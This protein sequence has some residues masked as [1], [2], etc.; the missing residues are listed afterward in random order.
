MTEIFSPGWACCLDESMSIWFNRYTCP[1]WVFC[2]RKPHPWG[3]EYHSISCGTSGIMFGI[4]MVEG[5]HRPKEIPT[6][7]TNAKG[8]TV[9]LLLRLCRSIYNSGR[10][11]ILDSGFCVLQGLI[12]LRKLGVYA[13][14]I[15][16]KRRYWPKHVPGKAMDKRM[17]SKNIGEVDCI[18]G[19]LDNTDYNLFMMKEPDFTMKMMAT[20]GALNPYSDERDSKRY[21]KDS[22]GNSTITTFKYTEPYSNHYRFRHC[23]NNHNNLRHHLSSIEGTWVTQRWPIRVLG[24]LLAISEVNTFLAFRHFVWHTEEESV[25]LRTF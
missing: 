10:V 19:K 5:D 15:I 23:V 1:G 18:Q 11:V 14:A 8:N 13:S 22:D 24:F 21:T 4:E 3:N 9:G 20:Y 6:D 2:P 17:E 25:T 7:P 16:K 12:E